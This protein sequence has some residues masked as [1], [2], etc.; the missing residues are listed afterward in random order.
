MV[1]EF[2]EIFVSVLYLTFFLGTNKLLDI[3]FK[4]MYHYGKKRRNMNQFYLMNTIKMHL[5]YKNEEY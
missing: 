4:V 2:K 1:F 3:I 5:P